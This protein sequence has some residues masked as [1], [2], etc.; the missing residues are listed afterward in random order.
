MLSQYT[1][2]ILIPQDMKETIFNELFNIG[3][4]YES[5]YPDIDNLV[6]NIKHRKDGI[7]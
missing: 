6:K 4:N 5:I 1:H 7:V 3:V 2:C